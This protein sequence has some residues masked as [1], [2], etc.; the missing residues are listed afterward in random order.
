MDWRN[1][2][3]ED[4]QERIAQQVTAVSQKNR[5]GLG[6]SGSSFRYADS[7]MNC[8]G[9]VRI[10]EEKLAANCILNIARE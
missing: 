9:N 7:L 6:A 1:G 10:E 4:D 3:T 2:W 8:M 5:A